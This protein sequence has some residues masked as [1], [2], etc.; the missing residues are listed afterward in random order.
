MVWDVEAGEWTTEKGKKWLGGE[1]EELVKE[2][3][4]QP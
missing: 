3:P 2:T 4:P 1:Q